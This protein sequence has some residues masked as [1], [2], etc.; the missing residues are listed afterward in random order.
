MIKIFS[1]RDTILIG[2]RKTHYT[3]RTQ[4]TG[5]YRS[6]C[7]VVIQK[8]STMTQP[9]N[10]ESFPQQGHQLLFNLKSEIEEKRLH[11][12]KRRS[13][14]N[15]RIKNLADQH[16]VSLD[17]KEILHAEK[18]LNVFVDLLGKISQEI[19]LEIRRIAQK[20]TLAVQDVHTI[21]RYVRSIKKDLS[22]SLVTLSQVDFIVRHVSLNVFHPRSNKYAPKSVSPIIQIRSNVSITL[23]L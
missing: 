11:L 23:G 18:S 3:T 6:L 14:I 20:E 17:E 21:K 2:T 7:K 8:T 4:R 16:K 19:D 15:D 1:H 22:I 12:Q 13:A 5:F 10:P 9:H